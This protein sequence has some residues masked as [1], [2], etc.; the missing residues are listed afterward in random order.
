MERFLRSVAAGA[1]A[2]AMGLLARRWLGAV[3]GETGMA[4]RSGVL[5]GTLVVT[6]VSYLLIAGRPPASVAPSP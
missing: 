5:V 4:M 6:G 3:L 1:A 2:G